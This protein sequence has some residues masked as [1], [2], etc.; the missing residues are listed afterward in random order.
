L[1][2]LPLQRFPVRFGRL[3]V[4][5]GFL[6]FPLAGAPAGFLDPLT[7]STSPNLVALFHATS[8]L[9][10]SLQS[11]SLP[12]SRAPSPT[13][14]PSCR[15]P[16][17]CFRAPRRVLRLRAPPAAR[18]DRPDDAR[19]QGLSPH[20]SP[21]SPHRRFRPG[22]ARGSLG[23]STLQG[24][25]PPSEWP[26]LHPSSPLE[27]HRAGRKR[28]H[29]RAP[30]GLAS[31]GDRLVSCETAYPPGLLRPRDR[32][33]TLGSISVR[34]SP[35]RASGCVTVPCKLSLNRRSSRPEVA[36]DYCYCGRLLRFFRI[37]FCPLLSGLAF[38]G[39]NWLSCPLDFPVHLRGRSVCQCPLSIPCGFFSFQ[40][41]SPGFTRSILCSLQLEAETSF[42]PA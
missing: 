12:C 6:P 16:R 38:Y 34:E 19:L 37:G 9:G 32:P 7:P 42:T 24:F 28:P 8:A 31:D 1:R 41:I 5:S 11:F 35:P 26:G 39:I 22:R 23:V 29:R 36:P 3:S 13:P 14:L 2:F 25:L 21:L 27:L 33:Q 15:L 4:R 18:R 40:S 20:E 30:Q 17:R 10:V